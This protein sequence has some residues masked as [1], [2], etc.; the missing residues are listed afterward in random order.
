MMRALSTTGATLLEAS[1]GRDLWALLASEEV[2][3]LITDTN[4]I[5][6][7]CLTG[8][9]AGQVAGLHFPLVLITAFD[10]EEIGALADELGAHV[11]QQPFT[12]ARLLDDVRALF[13]RSPA[14]A[15][16]PQNP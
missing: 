7:S 12:A 9:A 16:K 5:A 11:L 8:L 14:G 13:S 6:K 3:L 4:L 1:T 15:E 10:T 2:D